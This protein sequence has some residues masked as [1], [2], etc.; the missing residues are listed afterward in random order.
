LCGRQAKTIVEQV[1]I[2][3][4]GLDALVAQLLAAL[5]PLQAGMPSRT[6]T[7]QCYGASWSLNRLCVAHAARHV[8]EDGLCGMETQSRPRLQ[9][10]QVCQ[11]AEYR[12]AYI[13]MHLPFA[14]YCLLRNQ[15][16]LQYT[17]PFFMY[18]FI[19]PCP[20]W[21]QQRPTCTMKSRTEALR[22]SS[23]RSPAPHPLL[24]PRSAARKDLLSDVDSSYV[25]ALHSK[26]GGQSCEAE[27][28][29]LAAAA[30]TR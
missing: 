27:L 20:C 8:C 17:S 18:F 9:L 10:L 11:H 15:H 22:M 29:K 23:H 4:C 3:P 25:P 12:V 21:H 7:T 14:V 13:T 6:G 28:F 24:L 16:L 2:R 5:Y 19:I 1:P 26:A 30:V